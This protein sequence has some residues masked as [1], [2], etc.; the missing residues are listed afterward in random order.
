M[1]HWTVDDP[2]NG[3]VAFTFWRQK[4]PY[5][6]NWDWADMSPWEQ[7]QWMEHARRPHVRGSQPNSLERRTTGWARRALGCGVQAAVA[8]VR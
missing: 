6:V 2:I 1:A 3:R 8:V 5:L 4:Q 7:D